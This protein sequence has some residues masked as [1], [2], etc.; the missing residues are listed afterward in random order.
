MHSISGLVDEYE[1]DKDWGGGGVDDE[2]N[3]E[4]IDHTDVEVDVIFI[5]DWAILRMTCMS[6]LKFNS[7]S[8]STTL[9]GCRLRSVVSSVA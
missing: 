9:L 1:S 2:A 5:S 8:S 6:L 7:I 4:A 3:Q